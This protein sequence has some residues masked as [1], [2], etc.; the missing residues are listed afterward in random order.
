MQYDATQLPEIGL[1]GR[2][3]FATPMFCDAR[4]CALCSRLSIMC[5]T[6]YSCI[7]MFNEGD[8]LACT[9]AARPSVVSKTAW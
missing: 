3:G 5:T 8:R 2:H 1:S 7:H 4:G 6:T 9:R